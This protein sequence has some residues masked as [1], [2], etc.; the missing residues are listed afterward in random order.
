[1]E[2]YI[3]DVRQDE[4]HMPDLLQ[5]IIQHPGLVEEELRPDLFR[6]DQFRPE[7][8]KKRV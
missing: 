6:I 4:K 5:A 3:E 8:T 7:I 2:K 1:M